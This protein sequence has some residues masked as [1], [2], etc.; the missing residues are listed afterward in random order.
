MPPGTVRPV[1][2]SE[3]GKGR[4]QSSP[5]ASSRPRRHRRVKAEPPSVKCSIGIHSARGRVLCNQVSRSYDYTGPAVDV[6]AHIADLAGCGQMLVTE[7]WGCVTC[8]HVHIH[9]HIR[10]H[11]HIHRPKHAH[12]VGGGGDFVWGQF[13]GGKFVFQFGAKFSRGL[14]LRN[15][16]NFLLFV[17]RQTSC[18]PSTLPLQMRHDVAEGWGCTLCYGSPLSVSHRSTYP[19]N[20]S[21]LLSLTDVIATT[22]I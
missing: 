17:P 18:F 21:P 20:P 19:L 13:R 7:V 5:S 4:V 10:I 6:A 3:A 16:G 14:F 1:L 22:L 15:L 11:S 9:I 8:T 12:T 2:V